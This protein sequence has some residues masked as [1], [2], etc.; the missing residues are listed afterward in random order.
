M[1]RFPQMLAEQAS[2]VEHLRKVATEFI[3]SKLMGNDQIVGALLTGSVARGDARNSPWG[4]YI[5]VAVVLK[6]DGKIDLD[7]AFGKNQEPYIPK[8]C[9]NLYDKIGVAIEVTRLQD[10]LEI[11]TMPESSIFAKNES[12]VIFDPHNRLAQWKNEAFALSEDQIK[13]RA[14]QQYFRLDYLINDYRMEKWMY[15]EAFMQIA[16]NFNE[17]CECYLMFLYCINGFFVPRK[18]WLAYLSLELE[19]KPDQHETHLETLY[20]GG[21]SVPEL[22]KRKDTLLLL[23]AWMLEVCQKNSWL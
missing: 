2:T 22:Q 17:A 15:R 12:I 7:A 20:A 10:L 11:R 5:D 1:K 19:L 4:L 8:H 16:Q 6:D 3:V 18:D 9:I 13:P 23:Q 14:L 21:T